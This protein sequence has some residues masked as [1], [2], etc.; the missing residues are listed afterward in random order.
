MEMLRD[1]EQRTIVAVYHLFT[2]FYI[3]MAPGQ[4]LQKKKQFH[5]FEFRILCV[6]FFPF[7]FNTQLLLKFIHAIY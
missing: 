2:Y 4:K 3:K 5:V 7:F 6:A 1:L